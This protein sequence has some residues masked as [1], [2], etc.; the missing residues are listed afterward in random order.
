[1][2]NIGIVITVCGA[3]LCAI[4]AGIGSAVGVMAAGKASAGVTSENPDLFG[5]VLVLQALPGTQGIYGFLI[6]ILI[7]VRVGLLGGNVAN[8][9]AARAGSS[10]SRRFPWL[11]SVSS[12]VFARARRLLRPST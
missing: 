2:A 10:S 4:L 7:M 8:L 11:L 12:P 9:T 5:K 6:A 1:M 3:A